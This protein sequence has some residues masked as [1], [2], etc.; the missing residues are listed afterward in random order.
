MIDSKNLSVID[1]RIQ[2]IFPAIDL[3]YGCLNVLLCGD[4]YQL[5]SIGG[6]VLYGTFNS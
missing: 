2:A 6:K 4:L 1:D 5:P 3:L